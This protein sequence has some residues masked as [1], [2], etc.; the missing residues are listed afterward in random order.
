MAVTGHHFVVLCPPPAS[1]TCGDG[2]AAL[3]GGL[4]FARADGMSAE[5]D[6]N[7]IDLRVWIDGLTYLALRGRCAQV[8][9]SMSEH[10]RYLIK[11]DVLEA[12]REQRAAG[13][14]GI[15]LLQGQDR[16]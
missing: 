4:L 6:R 9:R 13:S 2:W 16:L 14:G 5:R 15:G 12:L 8:E 3:A 10:V 11:R 7:D 1:H